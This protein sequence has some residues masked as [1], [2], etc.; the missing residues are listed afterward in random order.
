MPSPYTELL[1]GFDHGTGSSGG[2][3]RGIKVGYSAG[4]R[5][6]VVSLGYDILICGSAVT[7]L[8]HLCPSNAPTASAAS[9]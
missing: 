4:G 8:P 2:G 3:W 7:N 6:Y 1:L 9:G 5:H